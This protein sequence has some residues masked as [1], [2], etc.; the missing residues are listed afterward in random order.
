MNTLVTISRFNERLLLAFAKM[1]KG[2]NVQ[3]SESGKEI[4]KNSKIDNPGKWHFITEIH[5]DETVT[6]CSQSDIIIRG[7]SLS[8]IKLD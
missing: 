1:I 8:N 4:Y 3:L 6:L 7:L 5:A 2:I